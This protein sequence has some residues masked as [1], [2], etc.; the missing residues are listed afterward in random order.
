MYVLT[1]S[2]GKQPPVSHRWPRANFDID[3][4]DDDP[5]ENKLLPNPGG[6]RFLALRS[7]LTITS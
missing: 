7:Y 1:T 3:D 6:D 5:L 2:P 4:D